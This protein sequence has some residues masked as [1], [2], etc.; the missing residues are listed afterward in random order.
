MNPTLL[1]RASTVL[2]LATALSP[3]APAQSVLPPPTTPPSPTTEEAIELSPFVVTDSSN[4]GYAA[5]STLAG[6][7]IKTDLRDLGSA[8]TVITPEFLNDLGATNLED[9][10]A[11]TTSTEI[12]GMQ[13]NFSAA[14]L[15]ASAQRYDLDE[16]R[17]EPQSGA[18]VRGLFTPNFTRG[19]FS[20]SIPI[21]SYNTGSITMSR[22]AN[23][24]LF[25][26]GSAAGVMDN[27]LSHASLGRNSREMSLR[28]GSYGARRETFKINQ[29]V[30]K[31]RLAVQLAGMEK[32][33]KLN[34]MKMPFGF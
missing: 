18:R 24:L 9:L 20:S 26:L 22:G 16:Q 21:D 28:I 32:R 11:Y 14:D 17:R 13:G 30:L 29:V 3:S 2:L 10:L 6:T 5:T 19:Y 15:G 25:G 27:G 33:G 7:R 12:G 4:I 34:K 1:T 31:N 8:I 23:S